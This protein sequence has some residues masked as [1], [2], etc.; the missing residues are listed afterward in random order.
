MENLEERWNGE[1]EVID[2]DVIEF[3]RK[4]FPKNE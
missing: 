4:K 3:L 1:G 2:L